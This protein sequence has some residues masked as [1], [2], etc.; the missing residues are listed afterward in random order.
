MFGF[1]LLA[2][3]AGSVVL[4]QYYIVASKLP[5]MDNLQQRASKFETTRIL[6]R[7]GNTLYEI[8]DPQA[9]RRTY[10]PISKI[11]PYL[12]AATIA[13]EDGNF[14]THPGFDPMAILRAFW[15]NFQNDGEVVSGA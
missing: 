14:Y 7:N 8:L 3:I 13:T 9:G 10:R 6:D 12:V 5:S 15:Q 4:S 11:S 2:I 1:V